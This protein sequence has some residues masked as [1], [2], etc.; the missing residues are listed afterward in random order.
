[1]EISEWIDFLVD[2]KE[3]Y[4]ISD[5]FIKNYQQ[6]P[7]NKNGYVY[8]AWETGHVINKEIAEPNQKWHFFESYMLIMIAQRRIKIEDKAERIY[9]KIRCPELLLWIAEAVGVDSEKVENAALDAKIIIDKEEK[10][11]RNKAAQN[12]KDA[13]PWKMI[14][15][16]IRSIS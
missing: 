16:S 5:D 13:I 15:D 9:R 10:L 12:I 8:F 4:P 7:N 3:H 11:A 6:S 14:E 2:K 1:M